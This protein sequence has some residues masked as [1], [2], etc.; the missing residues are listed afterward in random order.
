MTS[1]TALPRMHAHVMWAFAIIL[2]RPIKATV[3]SFLQIYFSESVVKFSRLST[4]KIT[5]L[6]INE[7][8]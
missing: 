4:I 1:S 7:V 3:K 6:G 8:E 2:G 5:T